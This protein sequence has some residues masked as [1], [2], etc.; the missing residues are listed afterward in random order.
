MCVTVFDAGDQ[1]RNNQTGDRRKRNPVAPISQCE[2]CTRKVYMR[3][4]V[5]KPVVGFR[6][7][8]RP[9]GR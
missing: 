4:D 1:V 3:P 8:S 6:K 5:G 2:L 7:S 9:G